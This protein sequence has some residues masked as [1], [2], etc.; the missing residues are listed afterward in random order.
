MLYDIE[1]IFLNYFFYT[2]SEV[3]KKFNTWNI[4]FYTLISFFK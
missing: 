3:L 4:I 2:K 1:L